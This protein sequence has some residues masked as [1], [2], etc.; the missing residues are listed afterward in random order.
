MAFKIYFACDI[1]DCQTVSD[2]TVPINGYP[3]QAIPQDWLVLSQ[4]FNGE[5]MEN[6]PNIIICP[7]H[8]KLF[9]ESVRKSPREA[10]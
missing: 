9:P 8:A 3:M 1:V 4:R 2:N 6:C 5:F 7:N 10:K